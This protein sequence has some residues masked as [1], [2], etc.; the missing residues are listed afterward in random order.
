MRNSNGL[1]ACFSRC[2]QPYWVLMPE[3]R[4]CQRDEG[5]CS[6]LRRSIDEGYHEPGSNIPQELPWIPRRSGQRLYLV[7]IGS[8]TGVRRRGSN[9][10]LRARWGTGRTP[11]F[12]GSAMVPRPP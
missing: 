9:Q 11:T 7:S 2:S 5:E 12:L 1:L 3:T 8:S 6:E 10:K 4:H